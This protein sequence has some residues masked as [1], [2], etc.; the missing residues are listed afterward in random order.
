MA[1]SVSAT[2]WRHPFVYAGTYDI[3]GVVV[4]PMCFKFGYDIVTKP[5]VYYIS[6]SFTTSLKFTILPPLEY[7]Y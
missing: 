6:K 7:E 4:C 1:N 5:A 3:Y 2:P